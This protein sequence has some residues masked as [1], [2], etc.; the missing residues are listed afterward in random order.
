MIEAIIFDL[1][2]VYCQGS[3]IDFM[4]KSYKV[5]G[6][7]GVFTADAEVIFDTDYNKGLIGPE[8][9]FR[10]VFG[11]EISDE[12]IEQIKGL[13]ATTWAPTAEM[14]EFVEGLTKKYAVAMISNSDALNSAKYHER[15]WYDFFKPLIL[16]HEVGILK[17]DREIYDI[18][19][20]QLGIPAEKCVFIDDQKAC[21]DA[22]VAL[23][24]KGIHYESLAQL[25]E[26]LGKL[27]VN[28]DYETNKTHE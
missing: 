16:S 11:V 21:V 12:K 18:C 25:K 1:G 23:G 20:E 15:G 3:F 2:G 19:L 26:E 4:N 13:W 6:I 27:D 9:C 5:L 10:K 28:I 8:E 14:L 22:A 17:P 7:D 24:M